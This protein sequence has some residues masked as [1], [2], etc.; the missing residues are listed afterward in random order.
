VEGCDAILRFVASE[1]SGVVHIQ[2]GDVGPGAATKVLVFD[3]HRSAWPAVLRGML[4][5]ARLNARL[6]VGR[7]DELVLLQ[8]AALPTAGIQIQ[9]AACLAGEVRIAWEDPNC[10]DTKAEWHLRAASATA[11]CR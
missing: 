9:D 11:C 4:A 8:H 6:F 7:N 1:D 10:D 2:C 3:M 5:A